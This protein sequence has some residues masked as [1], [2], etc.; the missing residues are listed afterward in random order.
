[1]IMEAE[2]SHDLSS[3]GWRPRELGGI[4]RVQTQMSENQGAGGGS[5]CLSPKAQGLGAPMS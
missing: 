3:A 1:M 5:P 4:I 2:K